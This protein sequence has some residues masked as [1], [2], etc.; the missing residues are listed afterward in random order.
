M[1]PNSSA[2]ALLLP[3]LPAQ[4]GPADHRLREAGGAR[5][6]P[7]PAARPRPPE[8]PAALLQGKQSTEKINKQLKSKQTTE[9]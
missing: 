5:P 9:K 6:D 2:T 7:R 4:R 8:R 3:P 1:S